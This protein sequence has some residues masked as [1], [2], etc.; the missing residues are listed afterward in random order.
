MD[1]PVPWVGLLISLIS[2][3]IAL[4]VGLRSHRFVARQMVEGSNT[5]KAQILI[6]LVKNF[7]ASPNTQRVLNGIYAGT[8]K[9]AKDPRNGSRRFVLDQQ[10]PLVVKFATIRANPRS[11]F[12][13]SGRASLLIKRTL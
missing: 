8:L 1:N 6:D 3:G 7:Y 13:N 2:V 5:R 9:E 4:F 12:A 11:G 10:F